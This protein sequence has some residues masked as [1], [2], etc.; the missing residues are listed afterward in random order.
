MIVESGVIIFVGLL[1]LFI[2]LPR[3]FA[4]HLLGYPLALDVAV[5][6]VAYALHWGTFSVSATAAR[7]RTTSHRRTRSTCRPGS[8]SR[9]R[10]GTMPPRCTSSPTGRRLPG[11]ATGSWASVSVTTP[12]QRRS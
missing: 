10:M 8:G 6:I 2:K 9:E 1:L 4:L 12:M 3:I 11:A 5:S 7:W